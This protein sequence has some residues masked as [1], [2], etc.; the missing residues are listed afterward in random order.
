MSVGL[1]VDCGNPQQLLLDDGRGH[2]VVVRLMGAKAWSLSV[3][4]S[5]P[6]DVQPSFAQN[7]VCIRSADA[8]TGL[9]LASP[10]ADA[11][12]RL[13]DRLC[14]AGCIVR[15]LPS[16]ITFLP[17]ADQPG[18][19]I[20]LGRPTTSRTRTNA[21]V[22]ALKVAADGKMSQ[23]LDEVQVLLNLHHDRIVG[24]YGIY[25]V[26]VQGERSLA[27]VLDYKAGED[28]ASWIPKGGLPETVVRG[29][30]SQVG[31]A[32]VYLHGIPMVHRDVKPTN[33]LCERATD[34]S[35]KVVLSDFEFATNVSD[36]KKLSQRV[37]TCGYVAPEILRKD[38]IEECTQET[39]TNVTKI[40]AFS[41]G[42]TIYAVAFGRNPFV[43][44]TE[45][46]TVQRNARCLLSFAKMDGR[47]EELA[48]L[49]SGLCAKS[50][51]QRCSTS[52]ALAH[53][54][55]ASESR[56]RKVTW[57][58]FVRAAHGVR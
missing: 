58:A 32:L 28:L 43:D 56:E 49:L 13:L 20:R 22:V 15:D 25:E 36:K 46:L 31:D 6:D 16:H 54:W 14:A 39:V 1:V 53:P 9:I 5:H 17:H 19:V 42:M 21:D 33:V 12:R 8:P 45:Q 44:E 57:A 51:R 23:L 40:D 3:T 2:P 4:S 55:F 34:G 38:W 29:I 18:G 10:T 24:A 27:M 35:V 7:S 37:G 26:K 47:S 30:I 52:E 11:Q 50:P 48:S 41:F